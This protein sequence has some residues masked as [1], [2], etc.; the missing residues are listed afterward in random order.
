MVEEGG[1]RTLVPAIRE[2]IQQQGLFCALYSD[3]V[4]HFLV[5]PKAGGTVD[6][7][8]VTQLGRALQELGNQMIPAYSPQAAPGRM[9]RSCHT[10]QGRR[11]QEL[12]LRRITTVEAAK[13]FLGQQYRMESTRASLSG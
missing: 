5:K 2:V 13:R 3:K 7:N 6:E 8:Q 10:W 9:E 11:P 12:R 4:S 1:G